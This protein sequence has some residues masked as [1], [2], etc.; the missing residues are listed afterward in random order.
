MSKSRTYFLLAASLGILIMS[1][2]SAAEVDTSEPSLTAPQKFVPRTVEKHEFTGLTLKGQLK[3]PDLSYIYKRQGLRAEQI[4]NI[5]ENFNDEI[6]EGA[7][8]F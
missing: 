4:V 7:G 8:E 3:K 2:L 1:P 6:I 5:P